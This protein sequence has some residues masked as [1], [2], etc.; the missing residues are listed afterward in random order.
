VH[1]KVC[2]LQAAAYLSEG[3]GCFMM[4]KQ[5]LLY[6]FGLKTVRK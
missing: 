4:T 3:L 5:R 1:R 6:R 2:C